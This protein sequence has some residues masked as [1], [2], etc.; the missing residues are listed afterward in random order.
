[1]H[2]TSIANKH[3]EIHKTRSRRTLDLSHAAA[4][5][6]NYSSLFTPWTL[7]CVSQCS[8]RSALFILAYWYLWS[9]FAEVLSRT[10]ERYKLFYAIFR[11]TGISGTMGISCFLAC[12]HFIYTLCQASRRAAVAIRASRPH[13]MQSMCVCTL[14]FTCIC[15]RIQIH[16][17]SCVL[18]LH[19]LL[20][21]LLQS[22]R[23]WKLG[24]DAVCA[25]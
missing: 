14:R 9:R 6:G 21:K 7:V 23:S 13:I 18:L 12:P 2:E 22:A 8:N 10:R 3:R 19:E 4:V 5:S 16:R 11:C 1:M 17:T 24:V 25:D 20:E 15:V